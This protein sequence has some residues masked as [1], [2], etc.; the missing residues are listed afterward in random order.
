ME[1]VDDVMLNPSLVNGKSYAQV[2]G[3]LNN[4]KGWVNS[5]MTKP[6]EL[7]KDEVTGRLMRVVSQQEN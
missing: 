3:L 2:R 6:E 4:S 1:S 5:V 7:I